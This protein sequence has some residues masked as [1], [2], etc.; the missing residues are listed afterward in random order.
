MLEHHALRFAVTSVDARPLDGEERSLEELLVGVLLADVL[1]RE[2]FL[3]KL[4]GKK[5]VSGDELLFC[6]ARVEN[7]RLALEKTK[8][9]VM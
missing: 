5:I 6:V 1:A 4:L 7:E 3:G 8:G 2:A 9:S